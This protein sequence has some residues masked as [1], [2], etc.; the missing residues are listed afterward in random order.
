VLDAAGLGGFDFAPYPAVTAYLARLRGLP[1]WRKGEFW[2]ADDLSRKRAA[3][4]A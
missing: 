1:A 4:A 2:T 3:V